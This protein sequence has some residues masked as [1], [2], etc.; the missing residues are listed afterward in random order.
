MKVSCGSDWRYTAVREKII[1]DYNNI[2]ASIAQEY[3]EGLIASGIS[4]SSNSYFVG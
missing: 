2:T 3:N 1:N 4:S